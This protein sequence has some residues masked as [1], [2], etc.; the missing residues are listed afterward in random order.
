MLSLACKNCIYWGMEA[1]S[2][3]GP[4]A[5]VIRKCG[6]IARTAELVGKHRSTV[7]RWLLP[8]ESGGTGGIVP[9]QHQQ[10]LLAEAKRAGI[11]LSP[12]DF[13]EEA[14]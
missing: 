8:K 10:K 11:E 14:A 2:D 6:G 13:F 1:S 12:A 7:N 9:A 5:R 4:A 3:I